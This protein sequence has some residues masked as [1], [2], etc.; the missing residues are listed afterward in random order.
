MGRTVCFHCRRSLAQEDEIRLLTRACEQCFVTLLT[1]GDEKVSAYLESLEMPAA[2]LAQ[3]HTVLVSN[4]QFQQM[5][6]HREVAGLRLGDV[7]ECMYSP[8]LGRCEETVACL[9]CSFRRSVEHTW[10]TGEG[11][12]QV[13]LSVPHKAEARKTYAITT[14]RVG[15]AVLLLVGSSPSQALK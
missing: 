4:T 6:S 9:L 11:L 8:L 3:D 7:L 12:R 14:E 15:D 13:P 1:S 5:A 2:L 10:L